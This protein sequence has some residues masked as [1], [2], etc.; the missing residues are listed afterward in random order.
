MYDIQVLYNFDVLVSRNLN[1]LPYMV[2]SNIGLGHMVPH[3]DVIV[4]EMYVTFVNNVGIHSFLTRS[5][6]CSLCFFD[7][8]SKN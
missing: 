4:N 7:G 8:F 1:V 2:R 5:I 3:S 6:L